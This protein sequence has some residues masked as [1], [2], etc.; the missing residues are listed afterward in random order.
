MQGGEGQLHLGLDPG[1]PQ[2]MQ[3]GGRLLGVLEQRGLADAG[4]AEHDEGAALA[5]AYGGHERV[6]DGALGASSAK[7]RESRRVGM[8]LRHCLSS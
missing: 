6:E 8:T 4:L 7:P 1:R 3:V 5:A 2:P